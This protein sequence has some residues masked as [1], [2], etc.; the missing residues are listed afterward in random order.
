[1]RLVKEAMGPLPIVDTEIAAVEDGGAPA[2]DKFTSSTE[3]KVRGVIYLYS[4]AR[5]SLFLCG[6]PTFLCIY[7]LYSGAQAAGDC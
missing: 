5:D 2:E 6:S 3:K 7:N 4:R 1:M